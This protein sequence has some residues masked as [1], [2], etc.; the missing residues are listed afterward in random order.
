MVTDISTVDE[1]EKAQPFELA[2]FWESPRQGETLPFSRS[3]GHGPQKSRYAD[4]WLTR[5]CTSY[6][7]SLNG[8]LL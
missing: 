5:G 1:V 2:G 3:P 4:T 7:L 8:Q 6:R